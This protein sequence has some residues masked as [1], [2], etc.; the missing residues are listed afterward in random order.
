VVACLFRHLVRLLRLREWQ[1]IG[2]QVLPAT[3]HGHVSLRHPVEQWHQ[4]CSS[5][6]TLSG[7]AA[8]SPCMRE[9]ARSSTGS[10]TAACVGTVEL[11]LVPM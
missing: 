1:A 7:A 6:G 10:T 3:T 2:S 5:N 11:D 8:S 9:S 4:D